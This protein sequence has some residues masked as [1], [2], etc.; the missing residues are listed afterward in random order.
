MAGRGRGGRG[1]GEN[2]EKMG[3]RKGNVGRK[4]IF[5]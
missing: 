4:I 5:E 1:E 2:S 3:D